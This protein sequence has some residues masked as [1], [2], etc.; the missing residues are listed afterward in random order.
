MKNLKKLL[1]LLMWIHGFDHLLARFCFKNLLD[2]LY[3]LNILDL[4][5]F[6][7]LLDFLDL[8]NF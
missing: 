8:L 5:D 1:T 7:D 6:F 2:L 3:A 4:F